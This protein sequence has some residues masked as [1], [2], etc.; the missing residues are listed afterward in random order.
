MLVTDWNRSTRVEEEG[1]GQLLTWWEIFFINEI[2]NLNR[3]SQVDLLPD[4][5]DFQ[6]TKLDKV[7]NLRQNIWYLGN[8]N[9]VTP[10]WLARLWGFQK[11]AF[12]QW[13]SICCHFHH[14]P[15]LPQSSSA[16][17]A[18]VVERSFPRRRNVS[19]STLKPMCHHLC[20]HQHRRSHHLGVSNHFLRV[21]ITLPLLPHLTSQA[22]SPKIMLSAHFK[23]PACHFGERLTNNGWQLSGKHY[24][25]ETFFSESEQK[26]ELAFALCQYF[27]WQWFHCCSSE[28]FSVFLTIEYTSFISFVGFAYNPDK[29]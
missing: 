10:K 24:G 14:N 6:F 1:R 9:C 7:S 18:K 8:S 3:A 2:G 26:L 19:S 27:F 23:L 16:N 17:C 13:N 20:H 12:L 22:F 4:F 21:I 5:E 29:V 28:Q 11:L 15:S 25:E